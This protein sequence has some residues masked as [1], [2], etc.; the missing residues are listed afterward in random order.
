MWGWAGWVL[1]RSVC[2]RRPSV[3]RGVLTSTPNLPLA[4]CRPLRRI[5]SASA[6]GP[7]ATPVN[8]ASLGIACQDM[9][10][11]GEQ[12][13]RHMWDGRRAAAMIQRPTATM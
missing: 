9:G 13:S 3:R 7:S 11:M 10:C 8:N 4:L 6:A 5:P 12:I 1:D 2:E